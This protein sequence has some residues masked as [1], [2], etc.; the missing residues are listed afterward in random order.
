MSAQVLPSG[1]GVVC[2]CRPFNILCASRVKSCVSLRK[3]RKERKHTQRLHYSTWIYL[4]I[5]GQFDLL[6]L[7]CFRSSLSSRCP[8]LL[9][10]GTSEIMIVDGDNDTKWHEGYVD[11]GAGIH[12]EGGI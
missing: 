7:F 12:N 9:L 10:Q 8:K 3:E 2:V 6:F 1:K 11:K 5:C 4:F